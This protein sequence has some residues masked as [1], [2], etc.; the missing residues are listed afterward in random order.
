MILDCEI[1][2]AFVP[3][4]AS[5]EDVLYTLCPADRAAACR[6][7]VQVSSDVHDPSVASEQVS[8]FLT[9]DNAASCGYDLPALLGEGFDDRGL[10]CSEHI[11]SF[12]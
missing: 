3:F 2:P 9:F 7:L 10:I 8:V 6:K 12:G 5:I 1:L 11:L 4:P